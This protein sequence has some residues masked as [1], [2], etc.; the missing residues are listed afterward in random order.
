MV[1]IFEPGESSERIERWCSNGAPSVEDDWSRAELEEHVRDE[2]STFSWILEPMA[3]RCG[4]TVESSEYSDDH[5]CAKYVLRSN[6]RLAPDRFAAG[7]NVAQCRACLPFASAP[8]DSFCAAVGPAKAVILARCS[9]PERVRSAVLTA[10][11]AERGSAGLTVGTD[12]LG[13]CSCWGARNEGAGSY[14][15]DALDI[16]MR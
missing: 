6:L 2:H 10:P 15:I 5:F 3:V 9:A 13:A 11:A 7:G 4:F 16:T 12:S 14:R 8:E 1:F